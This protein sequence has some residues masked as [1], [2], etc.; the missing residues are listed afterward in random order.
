MVKHEK[1]WNGTPFCYE[2]ASVDPNSTNIFV[3]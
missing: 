2:N 1:P 3:K